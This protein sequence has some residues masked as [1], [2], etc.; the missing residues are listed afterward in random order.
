MPFRAKPILNALFLSGLALFLHACYC[1]C[2]CKKSFACVIATA[3]FEGDSIVDQKTYCSKS[4]QSYEMEQAIKDS[5]NNFKARYQQPNV[6]D[7]RDSIY[8]SE[9]LDRMSCKKASKAEG[10]GF[11]CSCYK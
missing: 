2:D 5:I 3:R 8:Y 10:D 7:T 4:T 6:V 1:S 11:Y 9:K